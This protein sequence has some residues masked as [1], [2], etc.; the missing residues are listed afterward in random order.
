MN[1]KQ[2][3][4]K[5]VTIK[6]YPDTIRRLKSAAELTGLKMNTVIEQGIRR[7]LDEIEKEQ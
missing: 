5:N 7:R 6:L 2:D 3:N 1:K 4:K